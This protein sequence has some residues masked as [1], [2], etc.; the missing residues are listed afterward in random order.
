M[1]RPTDLTDS[2]LDWL[3]I[4]FEDLEKNL[5]RAPTID[6]VLDKFYGFHYFR[7]VKHIEDGKLADF[8]SEVKAALAEDRWGKKCG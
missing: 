8:R 6:E 4:A 5:K 1:P 7:K 2:D 3:Q